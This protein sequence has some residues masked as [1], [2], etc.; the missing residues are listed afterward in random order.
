MKRI[1]LSL[2][3]L[4]FPL[5]TF[6]LS[7][8]PMAGIDPETQH[9]YTQGSAAIMD[10][11]YPKAI[12]IFTQAV[13]LQ[14]Y[15]VVLRRDLAYAYYLNGQFSEGLMV[16]EQ[17]IKEGAADEETYRIASALEKA[18]GNDK[19]SQK[20]ISDGLRKFP[21]SGTLLNLKGQQLISQ[22]KTDAALS[23]FLKGIEA[24]PTF[25]SNY[26]NAAQLL[27]NNKDYVWASIY[28]EVFA[29]IEPQSNRT[30][31]AKVLLLN[32]IRDMYKGQ[33]I[34]HIPDFKNTKKNSKIDFGQAVQNIWLQ[35][36]I[37]LNS[38]QSIDNIIMFRTRVLLDWMTK[39]PISDHSLFMFHDVLLEKGYFEAYNYSLFGAYDDSQLFSNWISKNSKLYADFN[40][41]MTKNPYSPLP[42]DPKK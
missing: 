11:D 17:V 41:W 4:I 26:L 12:N 19:K 28:A 8:Q 25:S 3:A 39:Y 30:I 15:N 32:S 33:G 2:L 7:A 42:S 20:Y 34:D 27:Y 36:F 31:T 14:P 5:F 35:Q 18:K 29:L 21:K 10:R 1:Q 13:R 16:L 9:L 40:D 6:E 38:D 24:D 22:K 23:E 37:V